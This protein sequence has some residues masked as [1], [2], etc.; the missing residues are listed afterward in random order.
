MV[1]TLPRRSLLALGAALGVPSCASLPRGVAVPRGRASAAT[2]LGL[3]NERFFV[4]E[5]TASIE[6]EFA[7]ALERRQRALGV[8]PGRMMPKLDLLAV[9]GGGEDGAFGAGLLCG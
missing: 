3:P 4:A 1:D 2:V 8:A 7:G 5:R 6:R 9:S